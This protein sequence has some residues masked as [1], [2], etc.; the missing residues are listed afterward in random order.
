MRIV[1]DTNIWVSGLLWCGLPWQLLQLAETGR[2]E[3]CMTEVMLEELSEVLRYPRLQSRLQS[4]GVT[5]DELITYVS[6]CATFFEFSPVSPSDAPLVA[7]DPDDD[8]FIHC[9]LV[10][11]ASYLISGDHHLLEMQHYAGIPIVTVHDFFAQA[12]L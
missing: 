4:V 12:L 7:T 9:V 5:P 2:V 6:Q 8:I 11:K 3:I 10:A 1:I